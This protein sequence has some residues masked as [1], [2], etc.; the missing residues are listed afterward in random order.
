MNRQQILLALALREAEVPIEVTQFDERLIIQ[1]S[2]CVLQYA[3]VN[4]GYRFRWYL[5]GPYCTELTS[6]AFWLA[7]QKQQLTGELKSWRLDD[8]S[9][10]RIAGL[11]EL[12]TGG[13]LANLAKRLELLA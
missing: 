10:Q 11:K 3:G 9:R 1:K 2:V 6:D 7:G 12:F 8:G 5:R 13:S 4:M